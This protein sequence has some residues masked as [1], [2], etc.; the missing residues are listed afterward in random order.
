MQQQLHFK[1]GIPP[2]TLEG[3]S[4]GSPAG[5]RAEGGREAQL[6]ADRAVS[7][8]LRGRRFTTCH[9]LYRLHH[10]SRLH[11]LKHLLDRRQQDAVQRVAHHV[12]TETDVAQQASLF[13]PPSCSYGVPEVSVIG[14][15]LFM[16]LLLPYGSLVC[17][18]RV[19]ILTQVL[20]LIMLLVEFLQ[21]LLKLC[22]IILASGDDSGK[23]RRM[24]ILE[25]PLCVCLAALLVCHKIFEG[26]CRAGL[27]RM[28]AHVAEVVAQTM[29]PLQGLLEDWA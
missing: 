12:V 26:A 17:L 29:E 19:P 18:P 16:Q 21:P 6:P 7:W 27:E 11:R 10:F 23:G 20:I 28:Q 24:E 25:M 2:V 8:A 5:I 4:T 22:Q 14:L 15:P 1:N 9:S 13:T 3:Y